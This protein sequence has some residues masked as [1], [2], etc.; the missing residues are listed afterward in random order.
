MVGCRIDSWI[1]CWK[2]TKKAS[3]GWIMTS[4]TV[5]IIQLMEARERI[6]NDKANGEDLA[7]RLK[8]AKCITA[9]FCWKEG[10]NRLG[11]TKFE[12]CKENNWWRKK[13]IKIKYK[14]R[15]KLNS[16]WRRKLMQLFQ[17]VSQLKSSVIKSLILSLNHWKGMEIIQLQQEN[18][19]W[20]NYIK[21][22]AI[23]NH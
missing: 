8:Q 16:N 20:L 7:T 6:R 3:T 22:G 14:R 4:L 11:K 12:V 18:R 2:K 15:R 19:R 1:L 23:D 17:L 9:G 21:S 13:S 5:L 10:T